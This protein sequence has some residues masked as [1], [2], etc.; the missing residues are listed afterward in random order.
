MAG[1]TASLGERRRLGT[2]RSALGEAARGDF[3]VRQLAQ[4]AVHIPVESEPLFSTILALRGSEI[5]PL[6][7]RTFLQ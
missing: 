6:Q 7:A 2:L 3:D 4:T 5:C 1:S